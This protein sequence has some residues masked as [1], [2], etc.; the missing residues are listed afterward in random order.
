MDVFEKVKNA[1]RKVQPGIDE[2]KIVPEALLAKDLEIDSLGMV[3]LALA[4]EDSFGFYIPDDELEG[5]NTVE[6]AVLLIE[7]KL[8][9]KNA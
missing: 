3:E 6:D 4:I 2:N 8:R 1:I 5:V 9:A 7:S